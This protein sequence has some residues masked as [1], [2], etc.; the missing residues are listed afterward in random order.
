ML[1]L[2]A[3]CSESS[4]DLVPYN[5][6]NETTV[7][8]FPADFNNFILGGYSYMVKNGG[9]NGYGQELLIDSEA[10][11]D[12]LI[13][14]PQGRQSNK[15]TYNFTN[16]ANNSSFSFYNSAYRA[17]LIA[18]ITLSQINKLPA[19]AFKDNIAGEAYFIRAINY[20]EMLR[21][22]SK[23]PT[24]SADANASLGIAYITSPLTII[25]EP[26]TTVADC[27][28]KVIA[29]LNTAVTLIGNNSAAV[30]AGRANKAAVYGLLSR[31]HLYMGNYP[32]CIANADLAL[33]TA[34]A[35]TNRAQFYTSANVGL[36]EDTANTPGV[37]F[38]LVLNVVDGINPGV[39]Y[40]QSVGTAI[41]S[42]YVVSKELFDKY[43]ITDIRK[44]AYFKTGVFATKTYNNVGKYD[45]RGANVRNL[46]DIKV[47]RVEEILLNKAEAQFKLNGS[48]LASLDLVR[49]NRYL[50]FVTGN[51]TGVALG[52][53][54]QLERRLE[55]AFEMD[56]FYTLKRLGLPLVRSTVDGHFS[57]GT[58]TPAVFTNLPA[59][60]F[61]WQFPIPQDEIDLNP[62][63]Q[64]NPGY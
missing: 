26:R 9:A 62:V 32:A 60:D 11:T 42:E 54:I 1:F 34:G 19:S 13:L 6:V 31:V 29:D 24:Q 44:A 22:Y 59:N 17:A 38:K 49:S 4:I 50:P 64:Q 58:G 46:V 37:V 39:A 12:N 41:R 23:I 53:A 10:A 7:L 27:Y 30:A 16:T 35:P 14:N 43:L 61:K 18:N 5:A 52:N 55:L 2:A 51:E 25:R 48:G 28:A 63:I 45:G 56:R 47:I 40:S 20:F 15:D 3:A 57:D 33:A 8:Q 21:N 36:W